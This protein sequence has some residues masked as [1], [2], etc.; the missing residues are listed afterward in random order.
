M[1]GLSVGALSPLTTAKTRRL[2]RIAF[3]CLL[4]WSPPWP[5]HS[6]GR[7]ESKLVFGLSGGFAFLG[8]QAI[9]FANITIVNFTFL[10]RVAAYPPSRLLTPETVG[11]DLSVVL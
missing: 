10:C 11:D 2:T 1:F 3:V 6:E 5:R 9:R 7:L 8:R 4:R